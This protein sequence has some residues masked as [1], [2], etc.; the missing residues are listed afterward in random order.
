MTRTVNNHVTKPAIAL[1]H[2]GTIIAVVELSR[3]TW[4]VAGRVPGLERRPLKKTT[5]RADGLRRILENWQRQAE[6]AGGPSSAWS[7]PSNP[8]AT[9]S[10]WLGCCIA[11]ASKPT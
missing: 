2:D 1:N 6:R 3:T 9:A 4:V 11:M 7:S 10:G 5:D 8:D